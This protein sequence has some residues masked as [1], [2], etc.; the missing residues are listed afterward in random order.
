MA[1]QTF[2]TREDAEGWLAARRA[3]IKAEEWQP[4]AARCKPLTF[5]EH[6]E[7]WLRNRKLKP[8]TRYP[9][10]QVL[11]SR[12]LPTFWDVPL[13]SVTAELVDEW[14]YRQ[15][16]QTPTARAHAYG[17]LGPSSAMPSNAA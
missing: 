6:A 2:D 1:P 4:P 11:E 17:L 8:R 5:G 16:D 10:R 12:I 15:G 3:E 14:H 13:R 9:Y 7:T